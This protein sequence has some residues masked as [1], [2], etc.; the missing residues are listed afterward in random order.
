MRSNERNSLPLEARAASWIAEQPWLRC[1]QGHP[2]IEKR[3]QSF[4]KDCS[5]QVYKFCGR[6]FRRQR[7]HCRH[8][9]PYTVGI[10]PRSTIV[11][12]LPPVSVLPWEQGHP[13][14]MEVGCQGLRA[15]PDFVEWM[16]ITSSCIW[17]WRKYGLPGTSV[18]CQRSSSKHALFGRM[19]YETWMTFP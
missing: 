4:D 15:G 6:H 7:F 9:V 10:P 11:R 13:W 3:Y 16:C 18:S 2:D 8:H 19:I 5:V 14:L 1:Y 12:S 17:K